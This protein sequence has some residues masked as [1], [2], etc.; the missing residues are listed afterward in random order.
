M[1]PAPRMDLRSERAVVR[2]GKNAPSKERYSPRCITIR[3]AR[4]MADGH[5][6]V[7]ALKAMLVLKEEN[8]CGREAQRYSQK[9]RHH[10]DIQT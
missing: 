7:A 1:Q 8:W 2:D 4:M 3:V 10:I 9:C 6:H 5:P